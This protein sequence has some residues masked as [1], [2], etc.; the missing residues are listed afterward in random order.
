MDE[1]RERMRVAENNA[2][3]TVAYK[4]AVRLAE[5]AKEDVRDIWI[6]HNVLAFEKGF[7]ILPYPK[8]PRYFLG[9]AFE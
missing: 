5:S 2:E 9:E 1:L 3:F 7:I 8:T 4:E 6:Y